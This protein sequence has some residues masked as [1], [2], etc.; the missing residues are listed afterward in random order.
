[1]GRYSE[2]ER[3]AARERI[4]TLLEKNLEAGISGGA[5]AIYHNCGCAKPR[6]VVVEYGNYRLC[7]DCAL[8]YELAKAEGHIQ[9]IED[10]ILP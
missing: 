7:S 3:Q 5:K 2:S 10:F 8:H 6:V 9:N 4:H 1:M